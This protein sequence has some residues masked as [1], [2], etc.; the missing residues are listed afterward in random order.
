MRDN[1]EIAL[2]S[3]LANLC[4]DDSKRAEKKNV[5]II[6]GAPGSGKST[7]VA[8]R[9]TDNDLVVDLDHIC[10]ALNCTGELYQNHEYILDIALQIQEMLYKAIEQRSGKWADAYVVTAASKAEAE[11]LARRLSGELVMMDVPLDVCISNIRGDDRRK[12][13]AETFIDLA[14]RWYESSL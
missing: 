10:A 9:K 7:Y 4:R 11:K 14:S 2:R 12:D 1:T 5:Y 3:L 8:G 6:G 13:R